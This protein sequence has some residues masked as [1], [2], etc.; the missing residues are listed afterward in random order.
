MKILMT[1]Q[2]QRLILSHQVIYEN[3]NN[4]MHMSAHRL[5]FLCKEM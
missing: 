4:Q 5:K 1:H 3:L 2:D